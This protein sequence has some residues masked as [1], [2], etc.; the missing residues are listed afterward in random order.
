MQRPRRSAV[1]WA[2]DGWPLLLA[3]VLCAPLL[4]RPGYP[5]A[6][7]LAFVPRQP[8]TD[9]VIG[10]GDA[11]PRAVPVDALVSLASHVVDGGVLAR[12][13]LPLLLASAG[14]G[15]HRLVR[16]LGTTARL[17]VAG[18]A[19][20]NPYVVERL[21]LG[22]WALLAAYAALPW[23]AAAADRWRRHR[24]RA[25]LAAVVLWGA[26]A[27]ITPTGGVLAV[28]TVLVIGTWR[29]A[30]PVALLQLTWL[31]PSFLGAAGL[32]SDPD[33]VNAFG[34]SG[35]GPGGVLVSLVG[36][37]GIWDALSV[38]ASRESWWG[39]A[40][41]VTVVVVVALGWRGLRSMWGTCAVRALGLALGGLVLA[42]LV[43]TPDGTAAL[44]WLVTSVPGA[45]L[46][47]DTQK[48]DA[49]WALLIACCLGVVVD[50]VVGAAR[51][52]GPEVVVS[53]ALLAA[54][55]PIV[56]LPDAPVV[57]WPTLD[58]VRLPPSLT[59]AAQR[60]ARDPADVVVLPWAAYRRFPWTHDLPASEPAVRM[61]D[62]DVVADDSLV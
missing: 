11:A 28:L 43:A 51:R 54:A 20:W 36:T 35:D 46:L 25:D 14:W 17:A 16:P 1:D 8:L 61:F 40:T 34:A 6:R 18:F 55:L 29:P 4:A 19:V 57:T 7:D 39:V 41:S 62:A 27:S 50:R 23:L 49:W 33:G 24:S 9:A 44:R 13:L 31:L 48:Y 32:T 12:V 60:V 38:P 15:A 30:V 47:R 53:A 45:G 5:F 37:G 59:A 22:Q 2:L 52:A 3:A 42:A 10:L 56:L 21:A 26:V 58:P